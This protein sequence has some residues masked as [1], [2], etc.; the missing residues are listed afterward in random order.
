V[1]DALR[2]K[3]HEMNRVTTV[4]VKVRFCMAKRVIEVRWE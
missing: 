1:S 2:A 3:P 4:R